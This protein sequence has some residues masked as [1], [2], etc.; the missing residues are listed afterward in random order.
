M[1]WYLWQCWM[2]S[3]L[4]G[5]GRGAGRKQTRA[6]GLAEAPLRDTEQPYLTVRRESCRVGHSG[7]QDA[8]FCTRC[9][10]LRVILCSQV[11][12]G[13]FSLCTQHNNLLSFCT[14]MKHRS[15]L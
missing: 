8:Q 9:H 5:F 10:I 14:A 15:F 6:P 12:K 4:L 11:R 2:P 3:Q 7:N 13:L 1:L